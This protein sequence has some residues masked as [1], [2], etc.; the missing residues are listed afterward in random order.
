MRDPQLNGAFGKWPFSWRARDQAMSPLSRDAPFVWDS[1]A[2]W[3]PRNDNCQVRPR[4]IVLGRSR[5]MTHTRGQDEYTRMRTCERDCETERSRITC[6]R[7]AAWSV[8]RGHLRC[9]QSAISQEPSAP[10]GRTQ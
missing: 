10:K 5:G 1:Q 8:G 4:A 7:S 3:V 9:V 6:A 2:L